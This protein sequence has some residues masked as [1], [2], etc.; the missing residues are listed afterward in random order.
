VN[1]PSHGIFSERKGKQ[2]KE[3]KIIPW[4]REREFNL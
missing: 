4:E 2:I 1:S 3:E